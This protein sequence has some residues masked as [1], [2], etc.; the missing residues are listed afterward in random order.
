MLDRHRQRRLDGPVRRQLVLRHRH[1]ELAEARRPAAHGALPQRAR[2]VHQRQRQVGSRSPRTRAGLR[3][4]RPQPRRA[5]RPRRDDL[6]RRRPALEQRRRN[7]HR[8]CPDR[9]R[10]GERLAYRRSRR[11]RQPRWAPRS[12]R[13][14]LHR[15]RRRD[16]RLRC[17]LPER[18][19]RR[20]RP[21][22]PERRSRPSR[23][24]PLPRGRPAG[25]HRVGTLRP[26]PRCHD[27]GLRRRRAARH[28]CR[29][30]R[31][32]EPAVSKPGLARGGE[33]RPA[34]PRL[35]LRGARGERGGRRPERGHGD[36]TGRPERRRPERPVR[37]QLARPGARRLRRQAFD[38]R[39]GR[40][41]RRPPGAEDRVWGVVCRL[42]RIVDRLRPRL[43]S[44]PH[45]RQRRDPDHEAGRER[46]PGAAVREPDGP[47]LPRKAAGCER[48]HRRR[49]YERGRAR[50]RGRRLRQRRQRRCRDQHRRRQARAAAEHEHGRPLDRGQADRLLPGRPGHRRSARWAP[51][52]ARDAR[53][54]QLSLV[55]RSA[56]PLRAR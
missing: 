55:R 20:P 39:R 37:E 49:S 52:R 4:R 44:R 46:R 32:P 31:E 16:P 42:G 40:V 17:R 23:P 43:G 11:R 25:G 56:R 19:P 54:Q 13:C 2:A 3:G 33:G 27:V 48:R 45:A 51:A 12:L 24:L 9:G 28:I 8:G 50:A 34:R 6:D 36:R 38:P 1:R 21:S 41:L 14:R 26:H 47:G 35:P 18:P 53:R 29:E 7:V 10:D 5:H 15:S 22:L 30:R